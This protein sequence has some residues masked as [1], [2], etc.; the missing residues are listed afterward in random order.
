MCLLDCILST[1]SWTSKSI[2]ISKQTTAPSARKKKKNNADKKTRLASWHGDI[3]PRQ[4]PNCPRSILWREL[5]L[6]PQ[7][8]VCSIW[9]AGEDGNSTD[10][11]SFGWGEGERL[12]KNDP[13]K[14]TPGVSPPFLNANLMKAQQRLGWPQCVSSVWFKSCLPPGH[15]EQQWKPTERGKRE[16]REQPNPKSF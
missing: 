7:G 6:C 1:G 16:R 10:I 2:R 15:A 5:V 3:L 14:V 9:G 4:T 8:R 11:N 12:Y 13:N